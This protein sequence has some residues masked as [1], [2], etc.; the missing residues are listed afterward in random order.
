MGVC[1][2]CN[3]EKELSFH[4]LIPKTL[5]SKNYFKKKY[6]HQF[7]ANNGLYLCIFFSQ[8]KN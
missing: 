6:K 3:R 8:K 1:E 5:H 7:M 4:H 2:L